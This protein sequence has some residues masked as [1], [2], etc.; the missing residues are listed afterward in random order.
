MYVRSLRQKKKRCEKNCSV[1]IGLTPVLVLV[2]ISVRS[3]MFAAGTASSAAIACRRA[4]RRSAPPVVVR[5]AAERARPP[6]PESDMGILQW[7]DNTV[8]RAEQV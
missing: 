8:K 7:Y 6:E 3:H 2:M 1:L 4:Q 5:G